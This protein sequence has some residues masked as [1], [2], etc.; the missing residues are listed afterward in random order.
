MKA[1][2]ISKIHKEHTPEIEKI[3]LRIDVTDPELIEQILKKNNLTLYTESE[4]NDLR[5]RISSALS[6]I[7]RLTTGNLAHQVPNLK[8]ILGGL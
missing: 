2:I 1:T 6:R 8:M 3:S 5:Q 7:N 4:M